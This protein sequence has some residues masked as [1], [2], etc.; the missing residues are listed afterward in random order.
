MRYL[1][2]LGFKLTV[3]LVL[4]QVATGVIAQQN[5]SIV[6]LLDSTNF[7]CI[8]NSPGLKAVTMNNTVYFSANRAAIE[9]GGGLWKTD[10]TVTGTVPVK[11]FSPDSVIKPHR[12]T[13]VNGLIFFVTYNAVNGKYLLWKTDGTTD[14]TQL[15]VDI[16]TQGIQNQT[17]VGDKLFFTIGTNLWVS[18]GTA[19]GTVLV[20]AGAFDSFPTDNDGTLVS[21]NGYL[22]FSGY[23]AANGTELWKTDGT[24]ANTVLVKNIASGSSSST[25]R[26]MLVSNGFLYFTAAVTPGNWTIWKSDGS[27]SGTSMI[28]GTVFSSISVSPGNPTFNDI[29]GILYFTP[30]QGST[31][32]LWKTDGTPGGTGLVK[33]IYSGGSFSID[34]PGNIVNLNNTLYF[35]A[36]DGV[37]GLEL[38]KSDGSSAGTSLVKDIFPGS[39]GSNLFYLVS[40]NGSLFFSARNSTITG[41]ELW[42]SD[43][44]A[45]GTVLLKDIYN[46][47][48]SANPS[49]LTT[50]NNQVFLYADNGTNGY[51]PWITDGTLAGTSILKDINQ[52]QRNTPSFGKFTADA[53]ALYF[54]SNN[55]NPN[56]GLW[57]TDGTGVGTS[58]LSQETNLL[59]IA[60]V[61]NGTFYTGNGVGVFFNSGVPGTTTD[62]GQAS[63]QIIATVGSTL[64]FS[65][66]TDLWKSNGTVAGTLKVK[67]INPSGSDL[68]DYITNVNGTI[69][70]AASNGTNGSELWKTDGT[71]AGTVIVKDIVAGS[72]SSN[73]SNLT[74]VNGT[75]FFIVNNTQLWKSDGTSSGTVQ[76][77]TFPGT[78]RNLTSYNNQLFF[79]GFSFANGNELWKSDGTI[80]G[81]SM[82]KDIN[83]GSGNSFDPNSVDPTFT[84]S[85]S[86]LFFYANTP[87]T[88][89]EL[90]KTDGTSAGTQLVKD[91][92]PGVSGINGG[93]FADVNGILY[94]TADTSNSFPGVRKIWKTDG[95]SAGT[96]SLSIPNILAP[97]NL[98]SFNGSLYFSAY[99][100]YFGIALLKY[101]PTD[102]ISSIAVSLAA[103]PIVEGET[104]TTLMVTANGGGTPYKYSLNGGINQSSS[105]FSVF[106]GTYIVKVTDAD[107][108]V[109][110]SAPLTIDAPPVTNISLHI[111]LFLQG[112]YAGSHTMRAN[113]FDLGMS[114]DPT[115]AD[116]ITVSLW[117]VENLD[118]AIPDH[119]LTVILHTDG[120]AT[121][122]FPAAVNG[123]SWYIAVKHRNHIETWSKLPVLFSSIT[124]Y[125]F[126]SAL[127]QAFDDGINAP[128]ALMTGGEY[129]MYGGDVN[130]DG[131]IDASDLGQT[132]NDANTFEFGY[133][134]S[135]VTGDGGPDASDL[136]LI[137]N[138]SQLFLFYARPY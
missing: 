123:H 10:G 36:N 97:A 136:A 39:Q 102:S 50:I 64:Y 120:T 91:V 107:G 66:S 67:D 87:A 132:F 86:N 113:K 40:S 119:S 134:P 70:F 90:W 101:S 3:T 73:P 69:Y 85:N 61:S 128:M 117:S 18:D 80:A 125:D 83:P 96:E 46:G 103:Q 115:E 4:L 109:G 75:V 2:F 81:T 84:I 37:N 7:S 16:N 55:N 38:W 122:E 54:F 44:T 116:N 114:A 9:Q 56:N 42:K 29:N 32:H 111:K 31:I 126:S 105:Q 1:Y 11:V 63:S 5:P 53:T 12:L 33:T 57:K 133:I 30:R 47:T 106:E 6:K 49:Y 41:Q 58:F 93:S 100:Q 45:A 14:G 21:Y 79:I 74:N 43:G 138:N 26:G 34:N 15:V 95:T 130:Q 22:Y 78:P 17:A 71:A 110:T 127:S 35:A 88:G 68:V 72:G 60:P 48:S 52:T 65:S 112:F 19:A 92:K 24:P 99:T 27:N 129:A 13:Y 108:L 76:L 28:T 135:D 51:E 59:K 124:S 77:S 20:K 62:L 89:Y 23:D 82:I 94:F 98:I 121:I 118:N 137:Y 8:Y 25:P 104:N 131:G